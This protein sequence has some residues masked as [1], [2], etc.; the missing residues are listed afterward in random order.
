M[1]FRRPALMCEP[2]DFAPYANALR[3]CLT[4]IWP[5]HSARPTG[6]QVEGIKLRPDKHVLFHKDITDR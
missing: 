2:R 4:R 5:T 1:A 6:V 3:M